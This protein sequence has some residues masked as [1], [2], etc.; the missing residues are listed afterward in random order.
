[1]RGHKDV[2]KN[3]E[4]PLEHDWRNK[5]IIRNAYIKLK[6][7]SS[8]CYLTSRRCEAVTWAK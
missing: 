1:M 3:E 6:E 4:E 2:E 8:S 7:N 5:D